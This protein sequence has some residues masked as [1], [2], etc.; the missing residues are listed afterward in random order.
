MESV[1]PIACGFLMFVLILVSFNSAS[2]GSAL[3]FAFSDETE[4]VSENKLELNCENNEAPCLVEACLGRECSAAEKEIGISQLLSG[5][6][7]LGNDPMRI[8]TNDNCQTSD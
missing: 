7:L 6:I 3:L 8:D 2:D 4:A 5:N 1:R